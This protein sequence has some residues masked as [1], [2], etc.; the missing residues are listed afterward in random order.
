[1]ELTR[2]LGRAT[3]LAGGGLRVSCAVIR[4]ARSAIAA[5]PETSTGEQ[6]PTTLPTDTLDFGGEAIDLDFA[7]DERLFGG[8]GSD[9]RSTTVAAGTTTDAVPYASGFREAGDMLIARGIATGM[10]DFIAFPALYCYRHS[11]ELALKDL[12]YEFERA[13]TGEFKVLGTHD[14]RL[15]WR[16]AREVLEAMWPDGDVRQLELMG[17]MVEELAAV[18]PGG[19]Q[20]R[21]DRDRAGLV[22]DI[23]EELMRFDLRNVEAVMGKL[24]GLMQGALEG[25]AHRH[26]L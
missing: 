1:M 19:E 17:R 20:F 9:W 2:E 10:Q 16:A 24:I 5:S 6:S 8:S 15:I 14:L 7:A 21:Y 25:V 13:R 4:W 12:I 23:P 22:R 11:L 18:D 26:G 3:R